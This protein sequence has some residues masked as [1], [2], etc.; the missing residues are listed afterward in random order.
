M[1]DRKRTSST[2]SPPPISFL[3]NK[4][5]M[6]DAEKKML[7]SLGPRPASF[8]VKTEGGGL[9]VVKADYRS[10]N[11]EE[12]SQDCSEVCDSIQQEV[13]QACN[14]SSG[15]VIERPDVIISACS[16]HTWQKYTAIFAISEHV[17]L[18]IC[19]LLYCFCRK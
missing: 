3:G 12:N 15:N 17:L 9:Q 11:K 14:I 1:I 10:E 18:L 8:S 4:S 7:D 19:G 6:A 2:I 5:A 13:S 16:C